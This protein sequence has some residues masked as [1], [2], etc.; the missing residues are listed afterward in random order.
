MVQGR[1]FLTF[2]KPEVLSGNVSGIFVG[3]VFARALMESAIGPHSSLQRRP[4]LR[5]YRPGMSNRVA[6]ELTQF[7]VRSQIANQKI[8]GTLVEG[9]SAVLTY[10]PGVFDSFGANCARLLTRE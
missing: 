1:F 10:S 2:G 6:F 5:F 8:D 7:F 4:V 3:I 9:G